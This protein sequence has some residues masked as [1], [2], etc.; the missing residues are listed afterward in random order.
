MAQAQTG[1]TKSIPKLC[2]INGDDN[3]T[4]IY[5][6][7]GN[8]H[9]YPAYWSE[10]VTLSGTSVTVCSGINFHGMDLASYANV[11]ITPLSDVGDTARVYIEKNTT[12]NTIKIISTASI[13]VD[14]DVMISVGSDPDIASIYCRGNTGAAP[15]YP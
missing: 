4:T 13:E 14:F 3:T 10:T 8:N 15:C 11:V 1:K 7:M 2:K 5:K 6:N 9:A 12:N